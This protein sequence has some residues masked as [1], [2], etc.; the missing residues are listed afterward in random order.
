M[1]RLA[2]IALCAGSAALALVPGGAAADVFGPISLV[3]ASPTEQA[4]DAHDPTLSG[5]GRYIA[6]DGYFAGL[7]GVWRR[8]VQS[9]VVEAVAVGEPGTP[10]A[11][12]E[13]PSISG[14]GR[15]VSFTTTAR[16]VPGDTNEGPDVYVRDME[17]HSSS[18]CTGSASEACPFALASAVNG[19]SEEALTYVAGEQRYGSLAAGR[20]AL[21]ADGRRVAFVTTAI[22]N[23]AEPAVVNTPSLQVAVRDLDT[24]QTQLVSVRYPVTGRAEPVSAPEGAETFGA[25]YTG[26]GGKAPIFNLVPAYGMPPPVGASISADGSTVAWMGVDIAQQV[27]LL[28]GESPNPRYTEPLWRRIA[29]GPGASTRRIT[30]GSDPANPACAASG[31]TALPPTASLADPCQGPFAATQQSGLGVWTGGLGNVIP[32]LS[33]DGYTVAFLAD[34]PLVAL[35]AGFGQGGEGAASDLYVVDMHEGLTREAAL[36]PLT[37]LASGIGTDLATTAPIADLGVSPDG[38]KIAFS[39]KRT[40]FPLGSPAFVS[41]PAALPGMLELFEVDLTNDTLTRVTTGFEGGAS[42]HPHASVPSGEDPYLNSLDGALSP[43]FS[44]DGDTVAF[45][46]TASNLVYGDGNTPPNT[47]LPF[48]GSDAFLVPRVLFNSSAASQYVSSPP[49]NP[50][51]VPVRRLGVTAL[52]RRDGTV[53]LDVLVPAAG[54]LR[55]V[56]QGSVVVSVAARSHVAKRAARRS[57]RS[58]HERRTVVT[59]TVATAATTTRASAGGLL[60]LTLKL[61]KRYGALAG[62][63]GGFSAVVN[64][65]F[66]SSGKPA[67]R[68]SIAV[69]FVRT[70]RAKPPRRS[71]VAGHHASTTGKHAR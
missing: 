30:G 26:S 45:S 65:S 2:A 59:R 60:V 63:R 50:A 68:E 31:E 40:E 41:P 53:L 67:L 5:D 36:R 51:L 62:A 52:S 21:S 70:I 19:S 16:L 71:K 69:T 1:R 33:A 6:F 46:S 25:V 66:A 32:Q 48:D 35:G 28:S 49:A 43:S 58:A 27:P 9:G 38:S 34:A 20:S 37:E 18:P 7:S 64:L 57:S 61:A 56:A 44:N 23:L 15:Y 10:A 42:E 8:D 17:V 11:S 39:T 14:D 22:S 47:G 54:T 55:A 29:D 12:G 24:H 4:Q 3:S 13:L